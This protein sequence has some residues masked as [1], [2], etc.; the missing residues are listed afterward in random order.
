MNLLNVLNDVFIVYFEHILL[1]V[2]FEHV[3]TCSRIHSRRFT[4]ST[5]RRNLISTV[6]RLLKKI[7]RI[8]RKSKRRSFIKPGLHCTI[9]STFSVLE[10]L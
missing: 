9:Y 8:L 1:P 6:E 3:F 2:D 4:C 7:F 5:V 10:I